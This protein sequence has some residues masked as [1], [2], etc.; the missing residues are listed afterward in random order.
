VDRTER[1]QEAN[2][3]SDW[4]TYI[5]LSD[6]EADLE[7][8]ESLPA[9]PTDTICN[10]CEVIATIN[11]FTGENG[12]AIPKSIKKGISTRSTFNAT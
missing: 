6:L 3:E 8:G 7:V 10:Y 11:K 9:P 4:E 5:E 12:Y 2:I 1:Y